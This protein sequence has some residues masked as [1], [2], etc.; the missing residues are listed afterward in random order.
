MPAYYEEDRKTPLPARGKVEEYVTKEVERIYAELSF[1]RDI[2]ERRAELTEQRDRFAALV[3][4]QVTYASN[5]PAVA[6][7]RAQLPLVSEALETLPLKASYEVVVPTPEE[8]EVRVRAGLR[9]SLVALIDSCRNEI[10]RIRRDELSVSDIA[11]AQPFDVRLVPRMQGTG[12]EAQARHEVVYR[13]AIEKHRRM[14][15]DRRKLITDR[16]QAHE[17]AIADAE[18]NLRLL[19][20]G[21]GDG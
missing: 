20:E 21:Q 19:G 9:Y 4:L 6:E 16:I 2:E 18:E 14:L 3:H 5:I 1:S 13:Q 15:K 7:A 11:M 17:Q 12:F 10:A 8:L